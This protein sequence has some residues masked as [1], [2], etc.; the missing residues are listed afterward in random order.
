MNIN[1]GIH[2][3]SFARTAALLVALAAAVIAPTA[4]APAPVLAQDDAPAAPA[5][6]APE[7]SDADVAAGS[8]AADD[9]PA[10]VDPMAF[11]HYA[12]ARDHQAAG[13]F[14]EAIAEYKRAAELDPTSGQILRDLALAYLQSADLD[15]AAAAFERAVEVNPGDAESL[16]RLGRI[17]DT[18]G[19]ADRAAEFY[20]RAVAVEGDQRWNRYV[21][22]AMYRYARM[23]DARGRDAEAADLFLRLA[24]W[25][26]DAPQ[27]AVA[28]REVGRLF[29]QRQA[30]AAKAVQ[31]YLRAGMTDKAV[32]AVRRSTDSEAETFY[33]VGRWMLADGETA[34]AEQY[35]RKALAAAEQGEGRRYAGLAMFR[36]AQVLESQNSKAEAA[37]MLQRLAAWL[38]DLPRDLQRDDEIARLAESRGQVIRQAVQLY[39]DTGAS[40]EAL[41]LLRREAAVLFDAEAYG[42]A[43]VARLLADRQSGSALEVARL[44]QQ[45]R[46]RDAAAYRLLAQVYRDTGDDRAMIEAFQGYLDEQPRMSVIKLLLGQALLR[47]GQTERGAT[48]VAEVIDAGDG[49]SQS[50]AEELLPGTVNELLERDKIDLALRVARAAQQRWPDVSSTYEIL[51]RVLERSGDDR[52]YIETFR[53][54]HEAHPERV[55]VALLLGRKL[56]EAGQVDEGVALLEPISMSEHAQADAARRALLDHYAA[57][58]E[59]ERALR[60]Y[61]ALVENAEDDLSA[62][63]RILNELDRYALDLERP[64]DV[65]DAALEP[66][67]EM[68]AGRDKSIGPPLVLAT[69]AEVADPSEAVRQYQMLLEIDPEFLLAYHRMAGVQLALERVTDAMATLREATT[70]IESPPLAAQWVEMIGA[71]AEWL[72]RDA[73][74]LSTYATAARLGGQYSTARFDMAR[75]LVRLGRRAEAEQMI[76][77]SLTRHPADASSYVVAAEFYS[78]LAGDRAKGL[79]MLDLG[80]EQIDNPGELRY[81]KVL[82]LTYMDRFDE[83]EALLETMAADP[84]LS[85]IL[86]TLRSTLASQRKQYAEAERI[87]RDRLD[88]RP[89]DTMLLHR[90][91]NVLTLS[92]RE[93]EA[94][95]ILDDVLEQ[96]PRDASAGNDLGYTL[97]DR[98]QDLARA[99]RLIRNAVQQEPGEPAYLDSLGW[100]LY[101]QGRLEEARTYL[102]RSVRIDPQVDPVVWD[103]LGDALVRLGRLDDARQAYRKAMD[104]LDDPN[105]TPGREDA[106][107]R[108]AVTAKLEALDAGRPVPTAPLG[109]GVERQ[110]D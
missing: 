46:P 59:V 103:H 5:V 21:A 44:M 86:P 16:Y 12:L 93:D 48:L 83:A 67:G 56:I 7:V 6:D 68:N 98:G 85:F 95:A 74:A 51:S 99:E 2:P 3:R 49:L 19:Q 105:R 34:E 102:E 54:L 63:D 57:A 60:I 27:D 28:D 106:D 39:F 80:I 72:G 73:D 41:A 29:Q 50:G 9:G 14:D 70:H 47:A 4:L 1:A 20:Q 23:L 84:G 25:L 64:G 8:D 79:A 62:L 53:E 76:R 89:D 18:R 58:G 100:V 45:Q 78:R 97:A 52:Q 22:V 96:Y 42:P 65:L 77:G 37:A 55:A 82:M 71:L 36:L 92:G 108:R 69:L 32:E 61:V 13:R 15:E 35:F 38:A 87:L 110:A 30:I 94:M 26:A 31:L 66:L 33:T 104:M 11:Y 43:I 40:D 17:A 88:E 101:K 75:I 90:L 10:L 81:R 107:V 109:Q 24:T 91:A